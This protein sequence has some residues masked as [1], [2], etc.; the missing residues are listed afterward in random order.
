MNKDKISSRPIN[1]KRTKLSLLKCRA[2][3]WIRK[4]ID[5]KISYIF[6]G[7]IVV[8]CLTAIAMKLWWLENFIKS[9]CYG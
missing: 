3:N 6:W 4:K 8:M 7:Y 9:I 1:N 5:E 2:F